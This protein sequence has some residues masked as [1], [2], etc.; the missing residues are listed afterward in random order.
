MKMKQLLS[1]SLFFYGVCAFLFSTQSIGQSI[2]VTA[3]GPQTISATSASLSSNASSNNSI[4]TTRWTKFS[5]PGQ[6]AK[7]VT[8]IGSST[9]ANNGVTNYNNA[10][11]NKLRAY[12]Q[13]EGLAIDF[14]N[15][16]VAGTRPFDIDIN[17]AL[18]NNATDILLVCYPSNGYT[19]SANASVIARYF[20]FQNACNSRGIQMIVTGTQPR[21][22]F[23]PDDR[24]NLITMN[25]L[26]RTNFPDRFI[27]FLTPLLN[28]NGNT[29]KP[30]YR[31]DGIH[32]NDA[33][34]E[35]LYQLV[36]AFNIFQF[37]NSSSSNINSPNSG[38]TNITSLG[39]GVHRFQI[40]V[41]DVA[42]VLPVQMP[43]LH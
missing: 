32:P 26:F 17:A 4:N 15:L 1:R 5:V 29:M 21:D 13:A 40:A 38:N 27:D 7:R 22:D 23:S 14:V 43:A 8:V 25:N 41:G 12:Y 9:A 33:G 30:E 11:V 16:A 20:E 6:V 2:N 28:T 42:M 35:V 3:N 39:A 19:A 34:H 10:F 24:A 37:T 36:K 31:A 18:N